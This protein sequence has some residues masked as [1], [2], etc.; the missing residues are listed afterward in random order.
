M[1]A[2]VLFTRLLLQPYF[3]Y[4]LD[5]DSD[6]PFFIQADS[7]QINN[8]T[9]FGEYTGN[10]VM[11]QGVTHLTAAHA[12]TTTDNGVLVEATAQGNAEEQV[13]YWTRRDPEKPIFHAYA[14]RM[15][16]KAQEDKIYLY[17]NAHIEEGN[18]SYS[19]P[20]IEYDMSSQQVISPENEG[21]RTTII[22]H[23]G[24]DTPQ[25]NTEPTTS[26]ST[27]ASIRNTLP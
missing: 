7:A 26:V 9:G 11:D 1:I 2:I 8:S 23:P 10:V 25:V 14:N 16:Y 13:H 22:I 5:S 6:E 18:D 15:E 27:Q 24:N 20:I 19:A 12:T 21:G 3:S 17:G 4:A